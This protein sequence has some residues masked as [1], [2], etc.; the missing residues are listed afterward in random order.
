MDVELPP[1]LD[2]PPLEDEL[3]DELP[4]PVVVF[5]PVA[6]YECPGAMIEDGTSGLTGWSFAYSA[7]IL[8]CRLSAMPLSLMS[9]GLAAAAF[10]AAVF[11]LSAWVNCA[12]S[13]A[14]G[15]TCCATPPTRGATPGPGT[16]GGCGCL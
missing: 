3:D 8:E 10:C 14:S 12:S 7:A 11:A 6:L 16:R 13:C 2:D 15:S 1:E 5:P 9:P 4:A